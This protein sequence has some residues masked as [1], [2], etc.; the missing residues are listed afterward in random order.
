MSRTQQTNKKPKVDLIEEQVKLDESMWR[1][2]RSLRRQREVLWSDID[3]LKEN[4]RAAAQRFLDVAD[5]LEKN[6]KYEAVSFLRASGKR[7]MWEVENG[8]ADDKLAL[9]GEK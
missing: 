9:S 2:E 8:M 3:N 5:I 6:P 1:M 7:Y 4:L